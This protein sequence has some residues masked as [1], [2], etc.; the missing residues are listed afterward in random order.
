M[1]EPGQVVRQGH[2]RIAAHLPAGTAVSLVRWADGVS[3]DVVVP[4]VTDPGRSAHA[5]KVKEKT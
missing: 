1:T 2:A 5:V 4:E 3:T